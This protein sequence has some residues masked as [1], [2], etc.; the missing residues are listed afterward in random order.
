M[1]VACLM[2]FAPGCATILSER[3]YAVTIDNPAAQTYF[4]V[5]DKKSNLLHAGVT[6][7]QV[8]LDAKSGI[9]QRARYKVTF[10][11]EGS[12]SQSQELVAGVDPWIAGNLLLGGVPG[13]VVDGVSGAMWKLPN[14]VEGHV[15]AQYAVADTVQGEVLAKSQFARQ[16]A[17]W[18]PEAGIRQATATT[19]DANSSL[20]R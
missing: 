6:P 15:S 18:Q 10:A 11:G 8:T 14:R 2:S 1:A 17:P 12:S 3:R 16:S 20:M 19:S 13:M 9:F 7:Q 4:T 5:H